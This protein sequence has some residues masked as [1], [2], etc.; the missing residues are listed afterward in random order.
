MVMLTVAL[1]SIGADASGQ[2]PG[3]SGG[4]STAPDSPLRLV[5]SLAGT[6]GEIRNGRFVILDPR[7]SFR[8]PEDSNIVVYFEWLG[9]PGKHLMVGTWRGPAHTTTTSS[10]EYVA[11]DRSFSAYWE[12]T[13]PPTAPRGPWVLAATV[14][15]MPAG[16]HSFEVV[17]P[18]AAAP[19]AA[20]TRVPLTRQEIF[21]KTL[22]TAVVVEALDAAGSR[23][24]LGPG[25]VIDASTIAT[26]FDVLNNAARLR[27][28]TRSGTLVESSDVVAWHRRQ[29]WAIV[30]VPPMP[31]AAATRATGQVQPGDL[32]YSASTSNE[33]LLSVA[34][35]EIVGAGDTAG[36]GPRLTANFFSAGGGPG[37]PLLN[38]YG[39]LIG[40]MAEGPLER[41]G[42]LRF[43]RLGQPG[44]MPGPG[45]VPVASLPSPP[46]AAPTPIAALA[47]K[48]LF[49]PP[50]T[51]GRHVV[52]GGFATAVKARGASTQPIDQ[53]VEF[54]GTDKTLT[55][56]V[57]WSPAERIRGVTTLRIYDIDNRL[58]GETKPT[59]L[60]MRPGDLSMSA[61]SLDVPPPGTYRVDIMLS[62][63]I[64]WRGYFRVKP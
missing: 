51:H 50:V 6:K 60:S 7:N 40:M 9:P 57:T 44:Q 2:T 17:G 35:C 46:W 10:F 15:G 53:R 36:V 18:E 25:V 8:L 14:D 32:C 11:K 58:L 19:I 29:D 54:E 56:F 27:I 33:A 34:S 52:S 39:E 23:L 64:A 20:P 45:A 12:L 62:A 61:W 55:A 16:V 24:S 3:Q 47:A 63:D 13:L 59:K 31:V 42:A 48:G 22:D 37:A 38:E 28:R 41:A 49:T 30:P 43:V 26:S 4:T 1:T 21:A 5:R